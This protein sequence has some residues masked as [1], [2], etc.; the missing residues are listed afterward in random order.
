M[1]IEMGILMVE[2]RYVHLRHYRP[3]DIFSAHHF[4]P[5]SLRW[6]VCVEL[7]LD[8]LASQTH[9]VS[10]ISLLPLICAFRLLSLLT[11]LILTI[12]NCLY[13]FCY[14]AHWVDDIGHM[15]LQTFI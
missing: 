6:E 7:G 13:C 5:Y 1:G 3:L 14:V 9:P 10:Y 11:S 15:Y 8:Q 12:L 2:E 4:G